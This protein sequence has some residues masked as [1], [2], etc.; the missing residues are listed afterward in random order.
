M[1]LLF[2]KNEPCMKAIEEKNYRLAWAQVLNI[3]S[4]VTR[5]G[6][7]HSRSVD[8]IYKCKD[9]KFVLDNQTVSGRQMEQHR[10][11]S[12]ACCVSS[13]VC[14]TAVLVKM[15]SK[16]KLKLHRRDRRPSQ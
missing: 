5:I 1:K 10:L 14:Y 12:I 6:A 15:A 11:V 13:N 4:S 3:A 16:W 7:D 2:E 9:Y 8:G